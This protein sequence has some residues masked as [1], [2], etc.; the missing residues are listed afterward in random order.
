MRMFPYLAAVCLALAMTGG[1]AGAQP[2]SFGTI[3][4][5]PVVVLNQDRLF[6]ESLYGQR[7][8]AELET[9]STDLAQENR[10][11]E[12]RLL[13]EE[14]QLTQ[15]R[16]EM[17]AEEFQPLADAFDVRV[18]DIR[19]TQDERLR[20]L[21]ALA[22]AAERRFVQLTTPILRDLL[23]DQGAAAVLDSRAVIYLAEGADITDRALARI[24]RELGDG[25]E[26]PI[27]DQLRAD[28]APEQ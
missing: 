3:D 19:T 15:Q 9:A 27:L 13:E 4:G 12:A 2:L 10:D 5:P 8:Q 25:G 11:I 23:R 22:D 16:S 26:Q 17:S 21:N 7:V 18:E 20:E 1:G 14:Q 6:S 28:T 24:N